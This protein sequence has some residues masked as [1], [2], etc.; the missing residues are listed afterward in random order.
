MHYTSLKNMLNRHGFTELVLIHKK[1]FLHPGLE[2]I[3]SLMFVLILAWIAC[4]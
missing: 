4:K 3:A 1:G 2:E